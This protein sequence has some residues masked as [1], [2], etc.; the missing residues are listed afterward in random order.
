[1]DEVSAPNVIPV[2][3]LIAVLMQRL[4]ET[5]THVTIDEFEALG[6]RLLVIGLD[7]NTHECC[8]QLI[9]QDAAAVDD[10]SQLH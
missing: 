6:K 3:L 4:C 10:S 8:L 2:M 1:M 7:P 5:H 9:E